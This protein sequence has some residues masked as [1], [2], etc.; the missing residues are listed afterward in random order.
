MS[1]KIKLPTKVNARSP[2]SVFLPRHSQKANICSDVRY[3][4]WL[5]QKKA[6]VFFKQG[7]FSF[8]G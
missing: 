4:R 3:F 2:R 7:A 8:R 6:P 1:M 5:W